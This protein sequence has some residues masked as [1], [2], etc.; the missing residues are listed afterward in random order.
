MAEKLKPEPRTLRQRLFSIIKILVL[1][2]LLAYLITLRMKYMEVRPETFYTFK[3]HVEQ[4][5]YPFEEHKVTTEDGYILT[6]YRIPGHGK[7]P[8]NLKK[9]ILLSHGLS[10]SSHCWIVNLCT[11]APA[12][13]LADEN[14]D[15]W[16]I[17]HRGSYLSREHLK[18]DAKVDEEYWDF[19]FPDLMLY[20]MPVILDLVKK[21][22]GVSKVAMMGH[23]QGGGVVQWHMAHRPEAQDISIGIAVGSVG[24]VLRTRSTYIKTLTNPLF[25]KLCKMTGTNVISEMDDDLSMSQFVL[26]FPGISAYIAS[27]LYDINIHGDTIDNVAVYG[28][29]LK[30]GTSLKN[31]IYYRQIMDTNST[32]PYFFDYGPEGNVKKYGTEEPPRMDFNRISAPIAIIAGAHDV[33]A[34]PEDAGILA[35]SI[36]PQYLVF[37]KLDYNQ[38]HGGFV[39]SCNMSYMQDVLEL[40]DKYNK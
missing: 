24:G 37:S 19:S 17:N 32:I 31:L 28:Q 38:D 39:V 10:N 2:V 18:F 16:L 30:G 12:F 14:I 25:H 20:D 35:S 34:P 40:L 36:D 6:I 27:S 9:P 4:Y 1:P 22:T 15:V 5:G 8:S 13:I 3:Q 33:A 7:D 23:S 26:A 29:R 21:T 11:K